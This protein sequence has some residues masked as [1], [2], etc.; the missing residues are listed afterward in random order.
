MVIEIFR[1]AHCNVNCTDLAR[2]TALYRD[3]LGLQVGAHT[4]S[5]PQEAAGFGLGG[6]IQWDAHMMRGSEDRGFKAPF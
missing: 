1:I 6:E 3:L 4:H 2:S 5:A